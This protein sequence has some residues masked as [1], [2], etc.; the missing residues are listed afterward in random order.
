MPEPDDIDSQLFAFELGLTSYTEEYFP[1]Q[2]FDPALQPDLN[3]ALYWAE[4]TF[5]FLGQAL[6]TQQMDSLIDQLLDE[7]THDA[8]FPQIRNLASHLPAIPTQTLPDDAGDAARRHFGQQ[9]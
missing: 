6:T 9:D 1:E 3:K 2:P 4:T 7:A 8:T 5:A